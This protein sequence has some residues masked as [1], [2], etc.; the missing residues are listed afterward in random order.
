MALF[1]NNSIIPFSTTKHY[2]YDT[3]CSTTLFLVYF[4]N[5]HIQ[6]EN[7]ILMKRSHLALSG[8]KKKVL[9]FLSMEE[10]SGAIDCHVVYHL[11]A[12]L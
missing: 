3:C 11:L 12:S 10:Y 9:V 6:Q 7:Y 1:P 4:E 8:R 5:Y 2:L